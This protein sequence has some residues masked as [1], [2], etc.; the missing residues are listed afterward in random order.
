MLILGGGGKI[1][2]GEL[3]FTHG[4]GIEK[5]TPSEWDEKFAKAWRVRKTN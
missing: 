2:I 3:T 5:F 1:I 4:G